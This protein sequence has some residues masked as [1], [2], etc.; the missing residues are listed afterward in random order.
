MRRLLLVAATAILVVG[1]LAPG[2]AAAATRTRVFQ[3]QGLPDV[4]VDVCLGRQEVISK[5][6][7]GRFMMGLVTS[8]TYRLRVF[9]AD[10]QTCRGEKL[11]DTQVTLRPGANTTL[12]YGIFGGAP[13]VRRF[14]N[15]ITLP[16]PDVSTVTMRHA[17]RAPAVDGYVKG[18]E[19]S[20]IVAGPACPDLTVGRSCGP[21]PMP[22]RATQ[23]VVKRASDGRV[24]ARA[25][26]TVEPGR[27][28]QV[29]LLGTRAKNYLIA[30]IW[31]D[32]LV[33]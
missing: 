25:T 30:Y 9:V 26:E 22:V 8:D 20:V 16:S 3:V 10:Q 7:Y 15:D 32:A 5:F 24:L 29:Y 1:A 31:Q 28:Y 21:I 19:T 11:I 27:A 4:A 18:A 12:V 17:A 14:K 13:G 33:L 23:F 6:V 2:G